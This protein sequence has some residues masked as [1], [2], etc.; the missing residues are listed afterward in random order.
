MDIAE[1]TDKVYD[2]YGIIFQVKAMTNAYTHLTAE[3]NN[4]I[5]IEDY[6]FIFK[7]MD[8]KMDD[9]LEIIEEL[10]SKKSNL[11]FERN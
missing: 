11:V 2:M 1:V 3:N 4:Y 8:Q 6:A 10:E 5:P 9:I 7:T